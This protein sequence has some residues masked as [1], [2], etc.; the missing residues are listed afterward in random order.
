MLERRGGSRKRKGDRPANS[1]SVIAGV[2][3]NIPTYEIL[4]E[5]GLDLI[6]EDCAS[7]LKEVGIEFRGDPE[8]LQLWRGALRWLCVAEPQID[9]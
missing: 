9:R 1:Q 3:R 4:S 5:E 7:I 8:A 2:Q 6:E